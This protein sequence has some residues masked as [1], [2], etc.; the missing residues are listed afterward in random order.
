LHWLFGQAPFRQNR[1]GRSAAL[2]KVKHDLENAELRPI[3][4]K[5]DRHNG[6][7]K[8]ADERTSRRLHT[9]LLAPHIVPVLLGIEQR[10]I[11]RAAAPVL[12]NSPAEV[13]EHLNEMAR[14]CRSLAGKA[15]QGPQ[16][17]ILLGKTEWREV[18]DA[19]PFGWIQGDK[20]GAASLDFVLTK[21]A[22]N[23]QRLAREI[24]KHKH[25]RGITKDDLRAELVDHLLKV[26]RTQLGHDY[27][28][29]IAIIARVVSGIETDVDF[30]KATARRARARSQPAPK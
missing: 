12:D 19:M 1:N 15:K 9:F 25:T 23:F 24:P 14:L 11:V 16:P 18:L 3:L 21:A 5:L 13:T 8:T 30:V 6:R 2:E 29:D 20:A 10:K 28:A 17:S 26:F 27:A 22:A 4:A 7:R